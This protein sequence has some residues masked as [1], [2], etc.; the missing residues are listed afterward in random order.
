MKHL[1]LALFAFVSTAGLAFAQDE[2]RRAPPVE[3]PDFSNLDE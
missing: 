3:I 2:E 1:R